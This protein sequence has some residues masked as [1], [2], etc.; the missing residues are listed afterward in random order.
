M[1]Q[2]E[3][4]TALTKRQ[5][6][7]YEYLKDKIHN[8]GYGP[9][10][11]EIGAHFNIRSPNGV[12][13]HLKALEK[14]G[15]I[16]RESNMSRAIGLATGPQKPMSLSLIGTAVS[17]S[18]IQPAVSSDE[19][20]DFGEL[21]QGEDKGCLKIKGSAFSAL[22]IGDGDSVIVDRSA[23]GQPGSLVA[24][25][26]DHHSVTFC[27]IQAD[28]RQPAPAVPS[29]YPSTTRQILGAVVA[30]IRHYGATEAG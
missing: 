23:E 22:G 2:A 17:G 28:G 15:L 8:R 13:C 27:R 5:R 21:F 24:A 11:R 7:I 14:K 26:D 29:A 19:L 18:P 4:R 3:K 6:Q 25:L 12:M 20:V 9:T 30:V 1:A 10:V 16:H